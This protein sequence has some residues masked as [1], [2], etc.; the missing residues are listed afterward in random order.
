MRI[1]V[2]G[3]QGDLGARVV[4]RA[5]AAGHDVASAS[6]R[7]GV[8]LRTGAGLTQAL[9]GADAVVL[10]AMNPTRAA[11]VELEGTRRIL[12]A[13]DAGSGSPA[14]VVYISIVGC[15]V[16][17]YPYYGVKHRTEQVLEAWGG[18]ATV[19]RATQFHALAAFFAGFRVGRLG[20]RVGDMAIQPVDIEFVAQRLAE[21]ASGPAPQGFSRTTDLAGSD[22]LGPQEIAAMVAA[23]DG[24]RPPHLVRIPPVGAA[25]RS[26]SDRSNVPIG[27]ADIGGARFVDWLAGQPR[28]LPRGMHHAR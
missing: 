3:G 7:T 9:A 13:L 22:L 10:C 6:R 8:D 12:T 15:D 27:A 14:H 23:H 24:R 11:A 1:V 19:V 4:E 25:M 16:P 2:V 28:P 20:A 17:G 18:P 26:F 21:V 5:L